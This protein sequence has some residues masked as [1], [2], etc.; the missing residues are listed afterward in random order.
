MSF[1]EFY[2]NTRYSYMDLVIGLGY[3]T[4]SSSDQTDFVFNIKCITGNFWQVIGTKHDRYGNVVY[5]LEMFELI[6]HKWIQVIYKLST[7]VIFGLDKRVSS[8]E[9]PLYY[10]KQFHEHMFFGY[11]ESENVWTICPQNQ[12]DWQTTITELIEDVWCVKSYREM[13]MESVIKIYERSATSLATG[14]SDVATVATVVID[15]ENTWT[16]LYEKRY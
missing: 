8:D 16:L 5:V 13:D 6:D 1:P 9:F 7:E 2:R 4:L 12:L 3:W 15:T 10:Y 11:F 14:P